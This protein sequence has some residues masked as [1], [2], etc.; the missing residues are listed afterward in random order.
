[1]WRGTGCS[2]DFLLGG[3]L[4]PA[5]GWVHSPFLLDWGFWGPMEQSLEVRWELQKK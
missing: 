1:M 5:A 3:V 4:C 2:E